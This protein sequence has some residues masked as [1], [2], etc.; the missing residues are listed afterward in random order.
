MKSSTDEAAAANTCFYLVRK[1]DRKT[2]DA[3]FVWRDQP[4]IVQFIIMTEMLNVIYRFRS[5]EPMHLIL[6]D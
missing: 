5:T 2:L 6:V 1:D 4:L 3:L